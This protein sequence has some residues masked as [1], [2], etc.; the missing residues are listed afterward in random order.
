MAAWVPHTALQQR[1]T[2]QIPLESLVLRF[3]P[4]L[5]SQEA[6]QRVE[7]HLL[8]EHGRKDFFIQTDDRLANAMQ[9]RRTPC[10]F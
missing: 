8:R 2:G 9:K 1:L 5:A 4:P 6:A 7:R 10:R 3:Q